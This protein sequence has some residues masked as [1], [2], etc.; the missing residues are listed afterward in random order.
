MVR[1][2]KKILSNGLRVVAAPMKN[3][4][5]VTIQVLVGVGAKNESERL[6]GISHFLEH[7]FFKGTKN[8]PTASDIYKELDRV[9]ASHNAFTGYEITGFWVKLAAKYFDT[10][11]DVISDLILNP[12]FNEEE[13]EKERGVIL[14]EIAMYEDL[15]Q[16]KVMELL[17]RSA[18]GNQPAGRSVLGKKETVGAIKRSDIL[19]YRADNYTAKNMEIVVA[20]KISPEKVFEKIEAAFSGIKKGAKISAP[21]TKEKQKSPRIEIFSKKSDQTHLAIGLKAFD[22]FDERRHALGVLS[23]ILGGNSSSLLY[24]EIREKNG[25]AYYVGSDDWLQT[26][27]GLLYLRAGVSHANLRKTVEKI[28]GILSDLKENKVPLKVLNDAKSY[29]RGQ[30]ALGLETTDHVADFYGEQDL[31]YKKILQPDEILKKIE[32]VSQNDILKVAGDIFRP[33]KI[34]MAAIGRHNGAKKKEEYYKK[35]FSEI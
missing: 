10:G 28:K 31:F 32:K 5:A 18:F 26:D 34:V 9:G 7:L 22:M 13:M 1:F 14:Q 3:S 17:L 4:E 33:E 24:S 23:V 21:K 2:E 8:R 12:I 25:L 11:L 15:P 27:T 30:M 20:G 16:R 29:I 35:L 6:G 19:K